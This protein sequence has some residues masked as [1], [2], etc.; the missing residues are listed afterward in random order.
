MFFYSFKNYTNMCKRLAPTSFGCRRRLEA[1]MTIGKVL[2]KIEYMHDLLEVAAGWIRNNQKETCETCD[3]WDS[4]SN[5]CIEHRQ[6]SIHLYTCY[7][8]S[9]NVVNRWQSLEY[10]RLEARLAE[11]LGYKPFIHPNTSGDIERDQWENRVD[12]VFPY[13]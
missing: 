12:L 10:L 5:F 1:K 11:A 9:G 6:E 3:Y 7:D 13:Y 4:V 2:D 8:L